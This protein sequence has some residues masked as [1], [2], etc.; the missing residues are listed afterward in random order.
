M[1]NSTIDVPLY[2]G[3]KKIVTKERAKM[4]PPHDHKHTLGSFSMA[5]ASHVTQAIDAT[6]A[7]SPDWENTSF[8]HRAAVVLKAADLIA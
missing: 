4:A 1:Y 5:E 6:L 7:A 3:S 2:I 8:E